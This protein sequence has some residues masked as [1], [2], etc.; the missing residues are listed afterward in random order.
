M[1]YFEPLLLSLLHF[2]L[3][4]SRSLPFQLV[5]FLLCIEKIYLTGY[6]VGPSYLADYSE[7]T[8]QGRGARGLD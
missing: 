4:N 6:S 3:E 8:S 5:C 7:Y 1:A 2:L